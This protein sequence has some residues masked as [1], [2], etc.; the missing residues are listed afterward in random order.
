MFI[1]AN[2]VL[3]KSYKREQQLQ[4]QRIRLSHPLTGLLESM[5]VSLAL[6]LV[7]SATAFLPP[8]SLRGNG[9]GPQQH[10]PT[11]QHARRGGLRMVE[12]EAKATGHA[13]NAALQM[14]RSRRFFPLLFLCF[15]PMCYDVCICPFW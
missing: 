11:E 6:A 14:L 2:F 15:F 12:D 7:G 13:D 9:L 1:Q 3:S 4:W 10:Q 8:F 5:R